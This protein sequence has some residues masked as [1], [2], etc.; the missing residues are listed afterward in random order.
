AGGALKMLVELGEAPE[1]LRRKVT[2]PGGTTEAAMN[3][4]NSRQIQ[5]GII[6]GILAAAKRSKELSQP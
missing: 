5:Q 4:F 1:D 2:S 3:I 6:E